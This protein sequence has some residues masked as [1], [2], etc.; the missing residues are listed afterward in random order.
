MQ[1]KGQIKKNKESKWKI[2]KTKGQKK[3]IIMWINSTSYRDMLSP[4]DF[5]NS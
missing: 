2:K 1:W 5:V 4:L 3:G